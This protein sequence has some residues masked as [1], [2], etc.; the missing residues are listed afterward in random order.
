MEGIDYYYKRSNERIIP[1]ETK[2]VFEE[3]A[4]G[5]AAAYNNVDYSTMIKKKNPGVYGMMLQMLHI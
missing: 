1:D 3:V 4:F 5:L 2:Y